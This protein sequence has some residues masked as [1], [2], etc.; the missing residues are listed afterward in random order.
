METSTHPKRN[1]KGRRHLKP[2]IALEQQLSK[3]IYNALQG[4][5]VEAV[6]KKIKT[7]GADTYWRSS[8]EGHSLKVQE[9]LLP[10]FYRLCH[11]VKDK[12]HFDE[13]VDFYIT[14]DSSVNAFSVAAEDEGEPN[15]VNVNSALFDLMTED[16][17]RFVI[18]HELGHLINKDT[19]LARLIQF[20]FPPEAGIPVSLQYKIRLHDQLAELVADRYG[21][22]ATDDLGVCV[23]AFFKLASGLDLVK[24]N[25]SL[26]ALIAD[27]NRR[28]EYFLKDKGISRATHPVNPVRV[29][30]LNLF[31]TMPTQKELNEGMDELISILL[32]VGNSE[33]DE[34]TAQFV[35]SAGIIVANIDKALN[36]EEYH[37][38]IENLADLKIFPRKFIEEVMSGDIVKTFNESVEKILQ[39]NPGMRED[40]LEYMI[41]IVI[42]DK[43]IS[44]EEMNMLYDFGRNVGLSDMEVATSIALAIQKNYIPS[45]ESIS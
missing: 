21:Y 15:I 17:L 42:S 4:S 7:S 36:L 3:Q 37:V 26:D 29:Q 32:K 6:L 19:K 11:E 40:M 12:L 22:M 1:T 39:V 45:M 28:L 34:Y 33:L 31:S 24:M 16:E 41:Q 10:D 14:G 18:G 9:D 38:I 44:N 23:T 8:M 25:V 27:N 5:V 30:A 2:T 20:V 43:T 35:V 13:P